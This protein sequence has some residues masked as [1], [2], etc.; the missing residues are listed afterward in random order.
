MRAPALRPWSGLAPVRVPVRLRR[1]EVDI[2]VV[3]LPHRLVESPCEFAL[4]GL[5]GPQ[6][7]RQRAAQLL[8]RSGL[9]DADHASAVDDH[10]PCHHDRVDMMGLSAIKNAVDIAD[11]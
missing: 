5:F 8:K 1:I 10:A 3:E 2:A 9:V 7:V 11:G 4:G 6:G